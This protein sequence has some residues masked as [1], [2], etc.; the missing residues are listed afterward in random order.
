MDRARKV[1]T[2]P[3]KRHHTSAV[4]FGH[5]GTDAAAHRSLDYDRERRHR[6]GAYDY[7]A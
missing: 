4:G 1:S 2:V 7:G 6:A 3:L 5:P